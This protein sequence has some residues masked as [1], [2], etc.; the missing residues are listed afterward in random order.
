MVSKNNVGLFVGVVAGLCHLVWVVLVGAGVAQKL[1]TWLLSMHFMQDTGYT[2]T[3]FNWL[4]GLELV[5]MA[6][7]GGYVVGYVLTLLW[8]WIVKK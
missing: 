1:V 3:A 8:G 6:F 5:V 4:T 7:V 2:I